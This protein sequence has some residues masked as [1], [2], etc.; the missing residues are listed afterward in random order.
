MAAPKQPQDHKLKAAE[1]DALKAPF[2]YEGVDGETQTLPFFSPT[3]AGLTAGDLR[4]NRKNELELLYLILERIAD[5]DQLDALD[6][7]SVERFGEVMQGWQEAA[8]ADLPK[9]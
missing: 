5:E 4:K 7:L 1:A 2:E 3:A 8:G 9:S 6:A